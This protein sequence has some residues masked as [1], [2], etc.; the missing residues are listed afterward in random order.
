MRRTLFS[1]LGNVEVMCL[2]SQ[3]SVDVMGC[4]RVFAVVEVEALL[5]SLLLSLS[6]PSREARRERSLILTVSGQ[7]K[8][9]LGRG[10]P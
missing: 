2:A 10:S 8:A 1:V 7:I 9:R 4:Y 6:S 5:L 3:R